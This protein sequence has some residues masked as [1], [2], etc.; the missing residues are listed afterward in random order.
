VLEFTASRG[1]MGLLA[2][3]HARDQG[4]TVVC[5]NTDTRHFT[6]TEE[7]QIL[8]IFEVMDGIVLRDV[9]RFGA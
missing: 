6:S 2:P 7:Y 1:E 5:D 9:L 4:C 8:M 3:E